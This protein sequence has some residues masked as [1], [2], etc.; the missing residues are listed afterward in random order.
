ML[1]T[2]I[3]VVLANGFLLATTQ[4]LALVL[5]FVGEVG[6]SD[7]SAVLVPRLATVTLLTSILRPREAYRALQKEQRE[8]EEEERREMEGMLG[9]L[10]GGWMIG[11]PGSGTMGTGVGGT[12]LGGL[13]MASERTGMSTV[14]CGSCCRRATGVGVG[15]DPP[16]MGPAG[17]GGGEISEMGEWK[18][19]EVGLGVGTGGATKTEEGVATGGGNV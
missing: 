5:Y 15:G 12:T 8:R 11:S 6:W 17:T 4:S 13:T 14:V 10:G 1:A 7:C 18:A 2:F 9:G 3:T 19:F 16:K